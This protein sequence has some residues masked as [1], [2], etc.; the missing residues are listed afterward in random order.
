[1]PSSPSGLRKRAAFIAT[2]SSFSAS[3]HTTN[4]YARIRP[5]FGLL[6]T[7]LGEVLDG[8]WERPLEV[9]ELGPLRR[10]GDARHRR[11]HAARTGFE[12]RPL[13]VTN[14]LGGR[15]EELVRNAVDDLD[16]RRAA[17]Q[18]NQRRLVVGIDGQC[19]ARIAF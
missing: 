4:R 10:D 7:A 14:A 6:R 5:R 11:V 18:E 1:M 19:R 3:T 13:C 16:A 12:L 15:R 2:S 9:D 8:L 17:H